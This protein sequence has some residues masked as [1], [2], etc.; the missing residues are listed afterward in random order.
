MLSENPIALLEAWVAQG[1]PT[2]RHYELKMW[3]D[4]RLCVLQCET[5][6]TEVEVISRFARDPLA[7]VK[8]A[9]TAAAEFDSLN[10]KPP[11]AAYLPTKNT[12]ARLA[13]KKP[14]AARP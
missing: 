8:L 13:K 2:T 12:R 6:E 4:K 14:S 11:P 3:A 1:L 7:A 5:S 10:A 9:L